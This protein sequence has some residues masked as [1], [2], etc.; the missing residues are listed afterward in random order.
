MLYGEE[1]INEKVME[2]GIHYLR[3]VAGCRR[4]NH[5]RNEYIVGELEMTI[6]VL[7][8]NVNS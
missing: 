6:T 2:V 8:N 4:T 3:A 1:R 7:N 5:R